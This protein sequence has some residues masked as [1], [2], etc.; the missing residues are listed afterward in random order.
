M[1]P[2]HARPKAYRNL[3]NAT[4]VSNRGGKSEETLDRAFDKETIEMVN[5][6]WKHFWNERGVKKPPYVS[7]RTT[8]VFELSNT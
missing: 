6:G 4:R 1:T 3:H 5:A 2:L 7:N 8:G